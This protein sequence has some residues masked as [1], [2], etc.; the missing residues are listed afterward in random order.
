MIRAC[1]ACH[2]RD[3]TGRMSRLSFLRKTPEGWETSIR[4]MVTLNNV[5]LDPETARQVLRY[6]SNHQGLAPAEVLPGR[7]EAE[8]RLIEWQY[9]ANDT[10][11]RTCRACHSMGRAILQRRTGE[12]WGLLVA[13]HRG[14]YPGVDF[15]GFR[16]GGTPPN[17]PMDQA[18]AHLSRAFP[19]SSPEWTAWSATMRPPRLEGT[20]HVS[21]T[22]PGKGPFFGRVTITRVGDDEFTT[23]AVYRYVRTGTEARRTGR[24]IVYTGHQWRGRSTPAGAP[25]DQAWRE[26]MHV[27]PDWQSMTGRWFT[28]GY[29][30]FGMDVN[31]RR[32]GGAAVVAAVHPRAVRSGVSQELTL[33]G[34]NL[35]AGLASQAVD[36]GPGVRVEAVT[37]STP[38][39][40]TLRVR[41]DSGATI[42]AR[43]IFV[44]GTPLRGA[45]V[46]YDTVSRLVVA[47]RAG[48]ARV[49]GV[50][51]PKQFAQFEAVA[52]HN[53]PDGRPDTPDDINLGVVPATWSTE[54]YGVTYDDDDLRFIGS[55]DPNGL[56]TPAVDG[57][58]PARSGQRNNIG[59]I[60]V[61]ASWQPPGSSR[62]LR[63]RGLLVVTVP[64]YLRWEPWRIAP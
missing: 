43:D 48:M 32:A 57:P 8:R 34:D 50:Q 15:Q 63:A 25:P 16:G 19:L 64:L 28:G 3:S 9:T 18:I 55:L 12:E 52:W 40:A 53:G 62:S 14:Y 60:W 44:A 21:G 35:P 29:D 58:N 7:F 4:R 36:L 37:Q 13:M 42:G 27:E 2:T 33:Y 39:A 47:P 59:D 6:L 46:V 41:V 1:G 30:E 51:F 5:Q 61:V 10:T 22:E 56:F 17:H 31:L 45:I 38:T 24:S 23:E 49:G 54:E 26:V 20:W 11:N